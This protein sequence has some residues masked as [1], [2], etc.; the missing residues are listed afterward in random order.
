M[1]KFV[2]SA[3]LN[4]ILIVLV[5]LFILAD[6]P[7]L[8]TQVTSYTVTQLV[9]ETPIQLVTN[10]ITT[11]IHCTMADLP[12]FGSEPSWKDSLLG[13]TEA[14][15]ITRV[16]YKY[17]M[18]LTSDFTEENVFVG[19]YYIEIT[20]PEPKLL[21]NIPDMN[22]TYFSKTPVLRAIMD[23]FTNVNVE[24]R[25]REVFQQN[26]ERFAEE[27]GLKPTKKQIID[28]IE[29]FFNKVFE[30]KTGKRIIFK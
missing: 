6:R 1:W 21:E 9:H 4:A 17:G 18:D 11:M 5:A 26:M 12:E 2:I 28:N 15:F 8:K 14:I 10:S 7:P 16:K 3:I 20:L 22:Y 19:P 27:N 24:A 30:D 13:S 23:R 25:M 29:P